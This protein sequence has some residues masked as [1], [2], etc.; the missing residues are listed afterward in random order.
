MRPLRD[1]SG[2]VCAWLDGE[3]IRDLNGAAVA[4]MRNENII[5]YRGDHLGRMKTGYI[6][7]HSG[8]AVAWLEGAQGGPLLPVAGVAPVRPVRQIAPIAPIPPIPPV[9][10]IPSLGWSPG[11]WDQFCAGS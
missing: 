8:N 4:F 7:D 6:R 3:I 5:S 9:P 11:G 2:S 10:P 1:H